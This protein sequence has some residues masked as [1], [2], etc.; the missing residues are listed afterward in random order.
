MSDKEMK[1]TDISQSEGI[2]RKIDAAKA[3][4]KEKY[5]VCKIAARRLSGAYA[6]LVDAEAKLDLKPTSRL[7]ARHA[8]QE[9]QYNVALKEYFSCA[10][11]YSALV[12]DVLALYNEYYITEDGRAAKKIKSESVKFEAQ[13]YR[14]KQKIADGAKDVA[15]AIGA[16][17]KAPE[18][19]PPVD[20][21][22]DAEQTADEPMAASPRQSEK[23]CSY[24][25]IGGAYSPSPM[26]MYRP[27]MPQ[28]VNIAPM[29]IDISGIVSDAVASAMEKFKLAFDKQ[30]NAYIDSMSTSAEQLAVEVNDTRV[31]SL[32]ESVGDEAGVLI[33][34]LSALMENLKNLSDFFFVALETHSSLK[35]DYL[36][37]SLSLLSIRDIIRISS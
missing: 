25:A 12:E 32:A 28:G 33:E 22:R 6:R 2:R 35:L 24:G 15:E 9:T 18:K 19:N 14:L 36:V 3:T 13:Q 7:M 4:L 29:S 31:T 27:Y 20:T 8:I 16:F 11:L 37:Q 26:D 34:K 23:T 1:I 10:E 30:A 21:A 17:D 5:S